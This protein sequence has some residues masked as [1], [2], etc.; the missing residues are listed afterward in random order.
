MYI[1]TWSIVDHIHRINWSTIPREVLLL[2]LSIFLAIKLSIAP[3]TCHGCPHKCVHPILSWPAYRP[4]FEIIWYKVNSL[5]YNVGPRLV[6][7]ARS[8]VNDLH[9]VL[10][11]YNYLFLVM[12]TL[13]QDVYLRCSRCPEKGRM[14]V[15]NLEV[16][17]YVQDKFPFLCWPGPS[18]CQQSEYVWILDPNPKSKS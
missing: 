15:W 17:K 5:L 7:S 18:K 2:K 12:S 16:K 14:H 8:D 9:Q 6:L 4:A 11:L 1:T 13:M 3:G 10:G